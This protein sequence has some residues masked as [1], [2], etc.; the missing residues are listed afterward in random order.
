MIAS[1]YAPAVCVLIALALVPTIIH[2]YA[3]TVAKDGLVT[4][5]IPLSLNGAPS[6]P[7][8][9]DAAWGQRRLS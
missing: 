7:T 2:S 8:E 3:H 4:A 6:S 9:H 1:R 5:A